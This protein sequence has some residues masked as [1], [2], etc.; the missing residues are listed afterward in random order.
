MI[1]GTIQ[2]ED[3]SLV[4]ICVPHTGAPK[5]VRQILMGIKE[6]LTEIESRSGIL[7]PR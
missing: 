1:K 5:Y 3:I 2:E 4:N 7:T 6:R